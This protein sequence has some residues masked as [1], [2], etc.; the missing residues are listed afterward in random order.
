MSEHSSIKNECYTLRNDAFKIISIGLR[1][2]DRGGHNGASDKTTVTHRFFPTTYLDI[3][4]LFLHTDN[5]K[6]LIKSPPHVSNV[7]DNFAT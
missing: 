1:C 6:K 7:G 4:N 2:G 3:C 5:K